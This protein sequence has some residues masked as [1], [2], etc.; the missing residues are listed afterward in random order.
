MQGVAKTAVRDFARLIQ[1]GVCKDGKILILMADGTHK[2]KSNS[3]M[4]GPW[5]LDVQHDNE[6]TPL[7]EK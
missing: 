4:T 6:I 7:L 2:D 3:S 5:F 1:C